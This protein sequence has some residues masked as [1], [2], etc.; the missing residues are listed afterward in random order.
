MLIGCSPILVGE[1]IVPPTKVSL[2][3]ERYCHPATSS[4]VGV[5]GFNASVAIEAKEL[6]LDTDRDGLTDVREAGL[7]SFNYTFD[8]TEPD[9][10][11]DG[12]SDYF[13]YTMGQSDDSVVTFSACLNNVLD[14]DHD[15]LTDCEE[16]LIGTNPN[17]PDTDGDLIPDG[18]EYRFGLNALDGMDANAQ[19]DGD[20]L[21]NAQEIQAQ[22]PYDITNT[23]FMTD[24]QISY[25]AQFISNESNEICTEYTIDNISIGNVN[26]G[27]LIK[28]I[29]IERQ[30][31]L[32]QGEV[33]T[34]KNINVLVTKKIVS[35]FT[36]NIETLRNQTVVVDEQGNIN[37]QN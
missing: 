1:V 15:F 25:D 9:T 37:E 27:N 36:V 28:A 2:K 14:S 24:S 26:N 5:F 4:V 18:L 22:T 34:A 32:G 12:Y 3:I 29:V 19:L 21:T 33:F 31:V 11:G 13:A 20:G 16:S 35:G 30:V 8:R 6:A 17:N 23:K 7:V 10:N